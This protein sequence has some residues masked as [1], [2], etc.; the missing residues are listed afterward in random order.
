MDWWVCFFYFWGLSTY[1]IL[2]TEALTNKNKGIWQHMDSPLDRIIFFH[3]FN[4]SQ[5]I[6]D[7]AFIQSPEFVNAHDRWMLLITEAVW[8]LYPSFGPLV[9]GVRKGYTYHTKKKEKRGWC[10]LPEI[11]RAHRC[12]GK[13]KCALQGRKGHEAKHA[14]YNVEENLEKERCQRNSD[15]KNQEE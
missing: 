12:E 9:T 3:F 2:Q 15:D 6:M 13:M 8:T 5:F 11:S 1:F 4:L 7:W 14:G 10:V